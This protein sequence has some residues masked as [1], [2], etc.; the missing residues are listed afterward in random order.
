[1]TDDDDVSV[2]IEYCRIG[3]E[4]ETVAIPF[5]RYFDLQPGER[6]SV[7]SAP[8]HDH[9][10]DYLYVDPAQLRMT[11]LT[12]ASRSPRAERVI[13]ETFWNG[14]RNRV[15]ERQDNGDTAYWEM[16]L[17]TQV[18]EA[19]AVWEILRLGRGP[20]GLVPHYH[21][22]FRRHEDGSLHETPVSLA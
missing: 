14:G 5:E 12:V 19:P 1:M 22:F 17:E 21:G 11:R 3:A 16:I 10:V 13:S 6:P 18:S 15:I 2:T 8:R 9:A 20:H 4:P 7:R